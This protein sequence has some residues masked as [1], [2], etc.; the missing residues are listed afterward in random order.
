MAKTVDTLTAAQAAQMQAHADRW[1]EICLRTGRAD[2]VTFVA[3]ARKLYEYAGIPWHHNVLWV[4]SPR[5]VALAGPAA[6]ILIR[7]YPRGKSATDRAVRRA[8]IWSGCTARSALM[9]AVW[10]LLIVMHPPDVPPRLIP[11]YPSVRLVVM[12]VVMSSLMSMG[13]V[14]TCLGLSYIAATACVTWFATSHPHLFGF[15]GPLA[16]SGALHKVTHSPVY[17]ALRHVVDWTT[18]LAVRAEVGGGVAAVSDA[19]HSHL[20]SEVQGAAQ[21]AANGVVPDDVR[22]AVQTVV[23]DRVYGVTFAALEAAIRQA[24]QDVT[25]HAPG[26]MVRGELTPH[27]GSPWRHGRD[28]FASFFRDVCD[29]ELPGDLWERARARE[30]TAQSGCCWYPHRDFLIVSERP[31]EIHREWVSAPVARARTSYRLH[32]TDGPAMSWPDGWGFYAIHGHRVPAW[33]VEHPERITFLQIERE[34]NA[35][36]RR[37]MLDRYGWARYIADSDARIVDRVSMNHSILGLRGARLLS[38]ILPGELEPIVY[39]E[40]L[41]ST[42]EP[43]GT[44]KRYLERIDPN[45]YGGMAGRS[46]HAAMASRWRYRDDSGNLRLTFARWRDYRPQSE[47]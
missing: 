31:R 36:L 46:C 37:R 24:G 41:N 14:G 30:E 21:D 22:D 8:A 16:V 2:R 32:R 15:R 7:H 25:R 17:R 44:Y 1:I 42:P 23:G 12:L 29:L 10:A 20:D 27:S 40:M 35:E 26:E 18:R 4:S 34:P 33:M 9:A 43:D 3:A 38:K 28:A 45:A 11:Q 39:L 13:T 5:T 6:A 19:V 47:S